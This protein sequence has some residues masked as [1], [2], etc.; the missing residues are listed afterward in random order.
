MRPCCQ[1]S[2][3]CIFKRTLTI[4]TQLH[5]T[6]QLKC[7]LQQSKPTIRIQIVKQRKKCRLQKWQHRNSH[8]GVLKIK[9]KF[10]R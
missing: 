7:I 10:A 8:L 4:F 2:N 6:E 5:N 9:Q 1:P 3:N